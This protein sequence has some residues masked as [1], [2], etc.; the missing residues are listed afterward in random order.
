MRTARTLKHRLLMTFIPVITGAVFVTGVALWTELSN[1]IQ[2]HGKTLYRNHLISTQSVLSRS[3]ATFDLFVGRQL[4]QMTFTV[5][6]LAQ[7]SLVQDF[8][9]KNQIAPLSQQLQKAHREEVADFLT[10]ID[11]DGHVMASQPQNAREISLGP[12]YNASPLGPLIQTMK[13]GDAGRGPRSIMGTIALGRAFMDD[14]ALLDE[15]DPHEQ[16][17]AFISATIVE[18]DFGEPLGLLVVGKLLS[19]WDRS[20]DNIYQLTST[21]VVIFSNTIPISSAGFPDP[22][23]TLSKADTIQTGQFKTPIKSGSEGFTLDC[24]PLTDMSGLKIGT[25]CIGVADAVHRKAA[26]EMNAM[27]S[28]M[29]LN[30]QIW[31]IVLGGATVLVITLLTALAAHKITTPLSGISSAMHSLALNN[32]NVNI[33]KSSNIKEVQYLT[34]S[35]K[36]FKASALEQQNTLEALKTAKEEAESASRAKTVFLSSMS[37]ELRTPMNAILGFSQLLQLEPDIRN[38][39]NHRVSLDHIL[40]GG[41]RLLHMIDQVLDL[42]LIESGELALKIETLVPDAVVTECLGAIADQADAKNVSIIFSEKPPGR[43][44]RADNAR[45]NQV[46][47]NLLSNAIKF[48]KDEGTLAVTFANTKSDKLRIEVTDTGAGIPSGNYDQVFAPFERLGAENSAIEGTGI[49]LTIS[50]Q[51]MHIMGG[52]IGFISSVGSGSTFWLDVPFAP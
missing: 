27:L 36:V 1:S 20:L 12:K 48:N 14:L 11:L 21:Q 31:L 41:T 30:I 44:I 25:S 49:G 51:L 39:E 24:T 10:V 46:L 28:S 34:D 43:S 47:L 26:S 33:P 19:R 18:N 37:H 38:N 52:D 23:P 9:F 16:D 42:S 6:Q 3:R 35:M 32:L 13:M 45:L 17:L 22:L 7:S 50:K 2:N 8:I 5:D 40:S 4:E 29:W 15:T